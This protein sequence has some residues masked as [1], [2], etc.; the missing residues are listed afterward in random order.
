MQCH[1]GLGTALASMHREIEQRRHQH[2]YQHQH[3]H[4]QYVQSQRCVHLRM[5][6]LYG[7]NRHVRSQRGF[8]GLGQYHTSLHALLSEARGETGRVND[9]ANNRHERRATHGWM[10]AG[11]L[12]EVHGPPLMQ[13]CM[14]R[15]WRWKLFDGL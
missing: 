9:L 7:V 11:I 12:S 13:C 14:A 4:Q 5:R 1:D 2:R 3:Q 10:A 15:R 8:G 6:A